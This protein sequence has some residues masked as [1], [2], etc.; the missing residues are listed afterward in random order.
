MEITCFKKENDQRT[1][2]RGVFLFFLFHNTKQYNILDNYL[3]YLPYVTY[4]TRIRLRIQQLVLMLIPK[5]NLFFYHLLLEIFF[6][7]IWV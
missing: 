1:R 3:H 5:N 6:I 2:N 7:N 4:I